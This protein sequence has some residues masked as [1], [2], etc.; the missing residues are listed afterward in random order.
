MTDYVPI[1]GNTM[2]RAT[3]TISL[4]PGGPGRLTGIR[5]LP[6]PAPADGARNQ[7]ESKHDNHNTEGDQRVAA[8]RSGSHACGTCKPCQGPPCRRVTGC[9]ATVW[10]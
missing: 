4:A 6:L 9:P 7:E 2:T 8:A 1:V 3:E 10:C 5:E